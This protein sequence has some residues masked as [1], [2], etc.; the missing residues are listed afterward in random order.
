MTS[1]DFS[2]AQQRL[3]ARRRLREAEAQARLAQQQNSHASTAFDRLPFPLSRIGRVGLQS[4]DGIKGREGTRPAFRVGQVDAELLDE[5][6]QDLLKGQVGEA[7]KYFGVCW[8]A[9]LNDQ[10]RLY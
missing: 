7:L 4:W 5:E 1:A 6:L 3:A 10:I 9:L 2:L 8:Q